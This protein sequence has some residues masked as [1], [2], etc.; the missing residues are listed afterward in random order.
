VSGSRWEKPASGPRPDQASS[1]NRP[2]ITGAA[3][4]SDASAMGGCW[5]WRGAGTPRAAMTATYRK[6]L[7]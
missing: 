5:G 2:S 1:S 3:M 4:I 6:V 7:M